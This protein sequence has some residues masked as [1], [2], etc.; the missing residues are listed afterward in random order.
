ML[1]ESPVRDE[2]EWLAALAGLSGEVECQRFLAENLELHQPTMVV[3]LCEQVPALS[4]VDLQQADNVTRAAVCL[5][6]QLN[7]D[8]CRAHSLRA[9]G[10]VFFLRGEHA[11]AL[12]CYKTAE[13]LFERLGADVELG[14]TLSSSLGALKY[15]ERYDEAFASADKARAIFERTGDRVRLARLDANLGNILHRL[16]RLE[17]ALKIYR[18][19]YEQLSHA[20]EPQAVATVLHNIAVCCI[21]LNK[22]SEALEAYQ[23]ARAHCERQNLPLLRAQADYNIAYLHYLRGEYVQAMELYQATRE[24]CERVN[25]AYHGALCDLDQS[26][27]YL[28]L[29]RSE[30]GAELAEQAFASFEKQGL[31]YE[32]AKALAILAMCLGRQGKPFRALELFGKARQLFLHQNNQ[33]W[34]AL[35]DLYRALILDQEER[36]CEARTLCDGALRFFAASSSTGKAVLCELL[37]ARIQ[38]RLGDPETAKRH[39]AS[40]LGRLQQQPLPALSCQV[41]SLLGQIEEVAGHR[42]AAHDAYLLAY[43]HLESLRSRFQTEELKLGFFKDQQMVYESLVAMS[44]SPENESGSGH[45]EAFGYIQQAKSR[46]MADLVAFRSRALPAPT[47]MRS[48]LV[49]RVR[50][51][52][53]QLNWYYRQIDLQEIREGN[54]APER[55]QNLRRRTA[56]YEDQLARVLGDVQASDREFAALLNVGTVDLGVIRSALPPDTVLIEYYQARGIVYAGVL[57]HDHMAV[58]P[59]SPVGR[60]RRLWRLL[61]QQFSNHQEETGDSHESSERALLAT[62][63]VLQNLHRELMAPVR[64]RLRARRL[65]LAPHGFLHYLPFYALFD[66]EHYLADEYLLWC[67]PSSSVFQL[68]CQRE[69]RHYQ[70]SLVLAASNDEV[71]DAFQEAQ[72]VASLVPSPRLLLG[73]AATEERLRSFAPRSRFLHLVAKGHFRTDNPMFSSI[74]L[75]DS[76]LSLL[77]LYGLDLSAELITVSGCGL[78]FGGRGAGE[79]LIGLER[80]LLY[81]GAQAVL[82]PLWNANRDSTREFMNSFYSCLRSTPDKPSALRSAMQQLRKTRPHPFDWAPYVLVGKAL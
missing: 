67:V 43:H 52:R 26:E 33:A 73:D 79:E 60:V 64:D 30:D 82:L 20:A 7:D 40:A 5:A 38:F 49:E 15:L 6:E 56:E 50:E 71:P 42:R 39:C 17:E 4:Q 51:L 34:V 47:G 44:V 22:F 81:A 59:L 28:D 16:D 55:V 77:D 24:W 14:R 70:E 35:I 21:S 41:Y 46:A 11:R 65:I 45:E 37:L 1:S 18:R 66:G 61:Q 48:G 78:G 2:R 80:G 32:T 19:A 36:L 27:M 10:H 74:G 3:W 54:R 69:R 62:Q 31:D 12:E 75:A 53:E 9:T 23:Q 57:G 13:A 72:A 29:G 25:D 76:R 58:V 63:V 68:C 8:S